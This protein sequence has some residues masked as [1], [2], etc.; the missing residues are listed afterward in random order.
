MK[1][2]NQIKILILSCLIILVGLISIQYYLIQNT[3]KLTSET[4]VTEVKK[5]IAP[6]IQAPELDTIEER[7]VTELK[8]LCLQKAKDSLTILEFQLKAQFLADSLRLVSQNYL[9]SQLKDY[10]ILN[11]IKIR[12]QLQQI[13]FQ[14]ESANDTLLRIIDPPLSF[15][16]EKFEGKSFNISTGTTHSSVDLEKG[17]DNQP[18]EYFYK[19]FQSVDMDISNF[20]QKVWGKMKWMLIGAVCLILA[21][22]LLFFSMYR[23]LIKQKKIA[24]VKTDFV[25]NITHEL[26]TPLASL[27]L[28]IKSL[29]NREIKENQEKLND[30]I[31]SMERQN[32]R[33]QNIVDRVLESSVEEQKIHLQEVEIVQFLTEFLKDYHLD[34]HQLKINLQPNQLFLQTDTYQLGRVLQNLLQNAEK[35]SPKG[36]E[37]TVNGFQNNS[38]YILEIQDEGMGIPA[39]EQQKIF[40]K[41]Y[42]VSEGNRHDAKG[43]GLGLYLCK[44]I[45]K[46]LGGS[47]FVQSTLKKGSTFILKIPVR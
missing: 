3:Y 5:E 47:I 30:L 29:Q 10:P 13:I 23:S 18:V 16:G 39:S 19:H 15:I 36:S 32:N 27:N 11:E 12:V 44:Q 34:S 20:Q 45:M 40:E 14:T 9:D 24:E 8:N 1:Q 26:K 28:I 7:F 21:V 38:D 6:V 43:L 42:R 35:Y 33:I 31:L 37:I 25:N 4:Y 17:V 22:I 2:Q 41:F 46:S